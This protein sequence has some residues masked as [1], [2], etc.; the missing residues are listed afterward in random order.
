MEPDVTIITPEATATSFTVNGITYTQTDGLSVARARIFQRYSLEFGVDMRVQAF[1]N[2]VDQVWQK[3]NALSVADGIHLLGQ[4][5]DGLNIV[6]M[7]RLRDV[8]ICGLFFN[9]PGEDAGAYD[10]QAMTAK[11][12]AWGA[13]H[14]GFFMPRALALLSASRGSLYPLPEAEAEKASPTAAQALTD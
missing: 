1:I 4:L 7:N 13:V 5:R 14:S 6:G 12:E 3:L 10:F 9:A 11:V 2:G 8:E